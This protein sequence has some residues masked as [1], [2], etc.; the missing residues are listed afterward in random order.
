MD[1]K[2]IYVGGLN[3][4]SQSWD[5]H[6]IDKTNTINDKPIYYWKN[7][8]S[9]AVPSEAGQIILGDSK[10]K[11]TA[12]EKKAL[13]TAMKDLDALPD[14]EGDFID[15]CLDKYKDVHGFDPSSYGL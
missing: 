14:A 5:S 12:L 7:S 2:G 3:S 1:T 11:L 13:D 15:Q 10:M 8:N 9:G 6:T 4:A